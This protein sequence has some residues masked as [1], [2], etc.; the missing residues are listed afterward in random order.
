VTFKDASDEQMCPETIT[1][2]YYITDECKNTAEVERTF[3]VRDTVSPLMNWPWPHNFGVGKPCAGAIE[4]QAASWM[5][6]GILKATVTDN[7]PGPT[8]WEWELYP[9]AVSALGWP[10]AY[11]WCAGREAV[12]VGL[13]ALDACGNP[14]EQRIGVF[15]IWDAQGPELMAPPTDLTLLGVGEDA[16][17]YYMEWLA[18]CGGAV[19]QDNC[20]SSAQC[21]CYSAVWNDGKSPTWHYSPFG[22]WKYYGWARYEFT[23]QDDCGN[24]SAPFYAYVYA[25]VETLVQPPSP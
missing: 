6:S 3:T 19:A 15:L 22:G 17:T 23:L 10:P 21:S 25:D 16:F 5:Q 9:A 8:Y 11:E 18:N 14:S 12:T 4:E 7:C 20:S 1:R 2:T 24:L 13:T